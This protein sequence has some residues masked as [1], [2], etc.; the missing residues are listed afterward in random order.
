M[1]PVFLIFF[2]PRQPQHPGP[3]PHVVLYYTMGEPLV[4]ELVLS[5]KCFV[6][7]IIGDTQVGGGDTNQSSCNGVR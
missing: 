6:S 4:R 5:V 1:L 7:R 2:V 3:S